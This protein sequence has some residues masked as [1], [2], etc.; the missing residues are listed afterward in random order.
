MTTTHFLNRIMG[1]VFRTQTSPGLP[2]TVYLGLSTTQPNV[3]GSGVTEPVLA[4]GYSRVELDSLGAPVNGVISN[5]NEIS[6][7]EST[8]NWGSIKYFVLYDAPTNGN[9]LM[10]NSLLQERSVE[11]ATIVVI[12]DGCLK[13]TLANPT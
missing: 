3:D 2:N 4:S 8:G 6:F 7:P 13:L 12:K 11:A 10:Y 9:L 5:T 1:N